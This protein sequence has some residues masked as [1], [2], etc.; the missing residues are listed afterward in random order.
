M[1]YPVSSLSGGYSPIYLTYNE[2][3][4]RL[5]NDPSQFPACYSTQVSWIG[6]EGL[7]MNS[8]LAALLKEEPKMPYYFGNSLVSC[9]S[10]SKSG[11]YTSHFSTP[12]QLPA[13]QHW[14]WGPQCEIPCS[15]P[16][17]AL[18]LLL[19]T[20]NPGRRDCHKHVSH[21]T[22]DVGVSEMSLFIHSSKNKVLKHLHS[23]WRWDGFV[24]NN[25]PCS[26]ENT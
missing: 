21:P 1:Y 6:L 8:N 18:F 12:L 19:L 4:L 5:F 9:S 17:M 20:S 13:G 11:S 23:S 25:F 3:E 10:Q 22:F 24:H 15:H 16:S 26:L 7:S 2:T 14:V